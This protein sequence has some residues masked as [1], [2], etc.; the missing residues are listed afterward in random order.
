MSSE[1]TKRPNEGS[2]KSILIET[3]DGAEDIVFPPVAK[4]GSASPQQESCSPSVIFVEQ[5][6]PIP[7]T[8]VQSAERQGVLE[9]FEKLPE[10]TEKVCTI[11]QKFGVGNPELS[12]I[13][14]KRSK[15]F[16]Y[17]LE[18]LKME[19]KCW[20]QMHITCAKHY[21]RNCFAAAQEM[22]SI[23]KELV[24]LEGALFDNSNAVIFLPG[25]KCF[26]IRMTRPLFP[27]V[28]PEKPGEREF[29]NYD[30]TISLQAEEIQLSHLIDPLPF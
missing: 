25:F 26:Y 29:R 19:Y 17:C 9:I 4:K 27:P 10:E 30:N 6:I 28:V 16:M 2:E 20:K 22:R 11:L 12:R 23:L 1:G 21:T 7:A 15:E 5:P 24:R 13:I 18:L 14:I 3:D 8:L